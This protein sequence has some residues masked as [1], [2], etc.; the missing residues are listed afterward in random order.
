M[1]RSDISFV[2]VASDIGGGGPGTVLGTV[3]PH[4]Q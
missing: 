3:V 2:K 4:L 1:P